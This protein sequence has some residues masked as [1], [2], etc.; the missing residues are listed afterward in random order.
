MSNR[1]NWNHEPYANALSLL[2][3]PWFGKGQ[4]LHFT[5]HK[6]DAERPSPLWWLCHCEFPSCLIFWVKATE[7]K[8]RFQTK[9]QTC[10]WHLLRSV[11]SEEDLVSPYIYGTACILQCTL[12]WLC[13]CPWSVGVMS[14]ASGWG[15]GWSHASTQKKGAEATPRSWGNQESPRGPE[16]FPSQSLAPRGL[17]WLELTLCQ[18]FPVGFLVPR[19]ENAIYTLFFWSHLILSFKYQGIS[20]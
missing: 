10:K 18:S 12:M 1:L 8:L 5:E 13:C 17:F 11:L 19:R 15:E 16:K 6:M 7:G 4:A 20:R 3:A 14:P 2:S 9:R